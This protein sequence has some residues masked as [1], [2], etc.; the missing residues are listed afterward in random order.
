MTSLQSV[1][2]LLLAGLLGAQEPDVAALRAKLAASEVATVAW[3]AHDIGRLGCKE[4]GPELRAVLARCAADDAESKAADERRAMA[5]VVLDTLIRTGATLSAPELAPWLA[6]RPHEAIVLASRSPVAHAGL[7]LGVVERRQP[8][9]HWLAACNLLLAASPGMLVPELIGLAEV[10]LTIDVTSPGT[11]FWSD[12]HGTGWGCG[13]GRRLD[14]FPPVVWYELQVART[15]NC[16]A[17]GPL[18]IS[19]ERIE[20]TAASYGVGGGM[21]EVDCVDYA[22]RSLF[23]LAERGERERGLRSSLQR[24]VEWGG[25]EALRATVAGLEQRLA[26]EWSLLLGELAERALVSPEV[27][28]GN[29]LRIVREVND[30]RGEA[31]RAE[32]LPELAPRRGD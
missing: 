16:I 12:A 1:L 31:D 17:D 8:S 20:P 3:A 23:R 30:R 13:S 19:F 22:L 4:L 32:P 15:A 18:P 28:R 29:R 26:G 9:V 14:G 7:L 2:A 5:V 21:H 25:A 10:R 11:E 6:R 27:A 24:T